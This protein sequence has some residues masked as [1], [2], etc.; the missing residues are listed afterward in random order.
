MVNTLV[1]NT[2]I[3]SLAPVF[4]SLHYITI[5]IDRLA[6]IKMLHKGPC[7]LLVPM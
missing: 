7:V 5:I 6:K 4:N 2:L 3:A 1:V